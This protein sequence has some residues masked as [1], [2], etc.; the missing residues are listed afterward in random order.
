[1]STVNTGGLS[2]Q[3][4]SAAT[5]LVYDEARLLD[6]RRFEEWLQLFDEDGVYWVPSQP[7]Q[8]SPADALSIFFERRSLL[9]VRVNRLRQPAMHA[10]IPAPRTLHH[11]GAVVV[12]R[13]GCQGVDCEVDSSLIV[14]EWRNDE[15]R[16][17]AGRAHHRLRRTPDGLRIVLKRVDLINC[18]APHGAITVPL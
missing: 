13:S 18:D 5:R 9:A 10:Q 15:G 8:S 4:E 1:M 17:L 3:D 11:V 2:A 14:C 6:E 7:G 16:W 12:R